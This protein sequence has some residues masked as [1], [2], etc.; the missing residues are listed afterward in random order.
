[1]LHKGRCE[2][3]IGRGP[4]AGHNAVPGYGYAQQC[5]YIAVVGL[6]LHGVPEKNQDIYFTGRNQ[7]AYLLVAAK[8]AAEQFLYG[9]VKIIFHHFAGSAGGQQLMPGADVDQAG[10]VHFSP[11]ADGQTEVRVVMRYSGPGHKAGDVM[12]QI[13]GDDPERQ[14]ADDLRRFKQVMDMGVVGSPT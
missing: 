12:A 1:M 4:V 11:A 14:I 13:L 8:R 9:P 2:H 5:L 6:G 10:S 7:G 3:K